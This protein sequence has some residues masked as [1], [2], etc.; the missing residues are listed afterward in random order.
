MAPLPMQ[1]ARPPMLADLP[2]VGPVGLQEAAPGDLPV[3]KAVPPAPEPHLRRLPPRWDS[4]S[5]LWT[6]L[7]PS[8]PSSSPRPI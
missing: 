3:L 1:V 2:V 7:T 8:F 4:L 6:L 5:L